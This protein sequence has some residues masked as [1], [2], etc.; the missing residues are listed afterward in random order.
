MRGETVIVSSLRYGTYP[1]RWDGRA[2]DR[3]GGAAD[4]ARLRGPEMAVG[5]AERGAHSVVGSGQAWAAWTDA[6]DSFACVT[7]FSAVK[8][9]SSKSFSAAAAAP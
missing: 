3:A 5:A 1:V 2:S 7:T 9:N 8:P 4:G 6:R